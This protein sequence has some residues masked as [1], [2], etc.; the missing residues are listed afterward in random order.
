[1][2]TV[3]TQ[4]D[5]DLFDEWTKPAFL[6]R[7]RIRGFKSIAFCDVPLQP[8][9]V[10]VGRNGSGK[11]NFLAALAFLG[12]VIRVGVPGALEKHGPWSSLV[13]RSAGTDA[14]EFDIEAGFTC[15]E[16]P[17]QLTTLADGNSSSSSELTR[18][19]LQGQRFV[20][21]YRLKLTKGRWSAY[22]VEEE[23]LDILLPTGEVYAHY[24]TEKGGGS[25]RWREI[26]DPVYRFQSLPPTH[27][28]D[29]PLLGFLGIQPFIDLA[30]GFRWMG[31]YNFSPRVMRPHQQPFPETLLAEDGGNLASVLRTTLET[32]PENFERIQDYLSIINPDVQSLAPI[33]YGA[34]ETVHFTMRSSGPNAAQEFDAASMSDGTLRA[35]GTLAAAY[36][37]VPPHG[38]PSVIGIEEPETSLH[39][40]ASHALVSALDGATQYSQVLLTAHSPDLLG[41]R[42]LPLPC[43]LVVRLREGRTEIAPVDAAGREIVREELETLAELHRQNLLNPDEEQLERSASGSQGQEG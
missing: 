11:S 37:V 10:L 33:R 13:C 9:T 40:A 6:R 41:G 2:A 39:P 35:L 34:Y 5:S 19:D 25:I 23:A 17:R 20:A 28:S 16:P 43:V 29:F 7:V 22:G 21:R 30:D 38:H 26:P 32:S 4:P 24:G 3:A 42:N 36:Q 8:L 1:M 14:I 15:G 18:S 31:F 27:R 12:D